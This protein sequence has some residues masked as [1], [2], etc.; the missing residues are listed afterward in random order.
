MNSEDAPEE[1]KQAGA[2]WSQRPLGKE[3]RVGL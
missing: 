3:C 1:P 2:V